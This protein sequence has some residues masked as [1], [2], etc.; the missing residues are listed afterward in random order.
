MTNLKEV[1]PQ[2]VELDSI[3]KSLANQCLNSD[4][5]FDFKIKI[6][7]EIVKIVDK[8]TVASWIQIVAKVLQ[9]LAIIAKF[10]GISDIMDFWVADV[11]KT[12]KGKGSC[13][14]ITDL[15]M[16]QPVKDEIQ[17]LK[18]QYDKE[19]K[20]LKASAKKNRED[21]KRE[22]WFKIEHDIDFCSKEGFCQALKTLSLAYINGSEMGLMLGDK[23]NQPII[24]SLVKT[25]GEDSYYISQLDKLTS[26]E[27]RAN[28]IFEIL[29]PYVETMGKKITKILKEN[30]KTINPKIP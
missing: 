20:D 12:G 10:A 28:E 14:K 18:V 1:A 24:S 8:T 13:R 25:F 22:K 19:F 5:P 6:I 23:G 30:P 27:L 2:N 11:S 26:T 21:V 29:K 17:K 3:N 16:L 7:D 4:K 15:L 9:N